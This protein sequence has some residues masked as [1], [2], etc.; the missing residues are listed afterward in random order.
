MP[1]IRREEKIF[2]I[3]FEI[4]I[5][6]YRERV[7]YKGIPINK[8]QAQAGREYNMTRTELNA[9]TAQEM[10][11]IESKL[12]NTGYKKTADCM[13]VKIYVKGNLEVVISREW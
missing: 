11:E 4:S 2:L 1:Y 12:K 9:Y 3:F 7:E 8:A 13:W 10:R 6:L 5:D